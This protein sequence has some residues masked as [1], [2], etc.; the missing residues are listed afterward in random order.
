MGVCTIRPIYF[1][2]KNVNIGAE[3]N[4]QNERARHPRRAGRAERPRDRRTQEQ[5]AIQRSSNL[6]IT[7]HFY[8]IHPRVPHSVSP[9]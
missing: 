1:E 3:R 7:R 5:K 6:R 9:N 8:P 4:R 2:A